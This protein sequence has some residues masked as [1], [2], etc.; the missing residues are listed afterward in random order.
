MEIEVLSTSG[1]KP[2][3]TLTGLAPS[4]TI[5]DIKEQIYRKKKSLYPDRQSI[6]LEVRGSS[7]KESEPISSFGLKNGAKLYLKDLGPQIGWKTVFLAEYAGPLFVYLWFYTRPWYFYGEA[8]AS[9]P[10]SQCAKI[11]AICWS[12]HY[13]KRLLE[14]LF[15]HRFSHSTMPFFNLFKNC[16]YYWLFTAYVSYHVNHPLFTAPSDTQMY[17]SLGAFA[18]CELGN[19]SIHVALRNLRPPGTTVRKIPMPTSNPLTGLFNLVSCPNYTYEFGSWA[20]FTAMTQCLPAGIFALAG[21]YQ[22]TV[23][24]IGKHRL[25]KKEFSNYPKGRKA[26]LP[27]LI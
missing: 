19:L 2:V 11:A 22:M 8:A 26:I 15:V 18:L 20:A 6:R 16:S 10:F 4:T 24:A 9:Q 3:V 17:I 1:S 12:V 21:L 14:T 27:F 5:K 23:W 7:L 13:A 25:Y